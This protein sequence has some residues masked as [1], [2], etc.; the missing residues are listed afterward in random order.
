MADENEKVTVLFPGNGS[1]PVSV[2]QFL[3]EWADAIE[4]GETEPDAA[5]LVMFIDRGAKFQIASRRCN[6]DVMR[7]VAMLEIAKLEIAN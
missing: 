2:P 4:A 7:A 1:V 3:R 5:V 6:A